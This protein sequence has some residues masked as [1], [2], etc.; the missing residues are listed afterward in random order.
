M[1]FIYGTTKAPT[2]TFDIYRPL[3][4]DVRPVHSGEHQPF[5]VNLDTTDGR[6]WS[7]YERRILKHQGHRC[8]RKGAT[9]R[10]HRGG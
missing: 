2:S 6:Y 3:D 4:V 7:R 8:G 5:R 1:I 10:T 9:L